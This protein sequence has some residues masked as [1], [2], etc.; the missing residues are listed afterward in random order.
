MS[1]SASSQAFFE[2]ASMMRQISH[3]HIAL[4]YGVCV[5]HQESKYLSLICSELG[6][7]PAKL[8]WLYLMIALS[9]DIDDKWMFF[10]K[11]SIS[12]QRAHIY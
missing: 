6:I 3:K 5:R 10:D 8:F 11:Q 4:L 2:T 1:F 9:S 12:L 7:Y